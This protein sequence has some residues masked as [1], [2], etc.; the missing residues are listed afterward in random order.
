MVDTRSDLAAKLIRT[1]QAELKYLSVSTREF[2]EITEY[3]D[4]GKFLAMGVDCVGHRFDAIQRKKNTLDYW[5]GE[6]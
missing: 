2:P 3:P 6:P 1:S 4:S 5:D